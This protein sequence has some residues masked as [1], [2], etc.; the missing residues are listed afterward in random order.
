MK[1][2]DNKE[3]KR[4]L[5]FAFCALKRRQ[6]LQRK[7]F[8]NAHGYILTPKGIAKISRLKTK[9]R[10][11]KKL[12]KDQWLMVFFDIPEKIRRTRD[13]FRLS[14]KEWGFEQL[15]KSVWV[16]SYD[17]TKELKELI[18]D[19]NLQNYAQPLLVKK[20]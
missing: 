19:Y 3:R 14:L 16:T 5:Y 1:Y 10:K 18:R 15:Q 4:K 9:L 20:P 7:I 11:K 13:I 8:G 12:P 17:L 2:L 6:F